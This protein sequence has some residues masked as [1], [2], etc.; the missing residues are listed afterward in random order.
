MAMALMYNGVQYAPVSAK[1][2]I[3]VPHS[4]EVL[5]SVIGKFGKQALWMGTVEGQAIF[6]QLL[7]RMVSPHSVPVNSTLSM[8]QFKLPPVHQGTDRL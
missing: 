7:V 3:V 2:S 6:T 1:R 4:A 5:W 8:L